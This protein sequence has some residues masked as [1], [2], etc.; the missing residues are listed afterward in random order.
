M[1]STLKGQPLANGGSNVSSLRCRGKRP[2]GLNTFFFIHME[3]TFKSIN[4]KT[5]NP[6]T[7]S[8][9]F[10]VP[11]ISTSGAGYT[12]VPFAFGATTTTKKG[13]I[14]GL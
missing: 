9:I 13:I 8:L 10:P 6:E 11:K 5:K 4:L 12:I 14:L 7:K 3:N 2:L 1:N